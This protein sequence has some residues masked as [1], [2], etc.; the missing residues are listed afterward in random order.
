M[1]HICAACGRVYPDSSEEILKGCTCGGKK[2]YFERPAAQRKRAAPT[3]PAP[4][5]EP[6]H[7]P[8]E[9]GADENDRF[10]RV[11]SVRII[12][13]G[14]YELNIEKMA[15]S[16]ERVVGL[17]QEGSYALDLLSMAGSKKKKKI[18]R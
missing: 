18:R 8:E 13:P 3:S 12:A 7:V 10:D 1:V 4:E 17:G 5:P 16:D 9:A 11:E 6:E 2:F 14:T 15:R